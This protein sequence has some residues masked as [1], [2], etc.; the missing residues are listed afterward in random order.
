MQTKWSK[1]HWN[2]PSDWKWPICDEVIEF[3]RL[4]KTVENPLVF[5]FGLKIVVIVSLFKLIIFKSW[6]TEVYKKQSK[7]HWFF[8]S[9][10]KRDHQD[11]IYRYHLYQHRRKH[12][13][14]RGG[15]AVWALLRGAKVYICIKINDKVCM[16]QAPTSSSSAS[17]PAASWKPRGGQHRDVRGGGWV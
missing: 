6:P 14:V 10:W 7:N 8:P 9:D 2:F 1:N 3:H 17:A 11:H 5:T 13:D 12:S 16:T 15:W 4:C